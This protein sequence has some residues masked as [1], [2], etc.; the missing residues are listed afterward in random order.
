M[1]LTV[2]LDFGDA[3]APYPTLLA[4]NGARHEATGLTLG[5]NRDDELNGVHSTTANAD[6]T[7]GSPDDEDGVTFGT[8]QVGQ[9]GATVTVNVQGITTTGKLDAWIDFNGDGS[10]GGPGEQIA[11]HVAMVDGNNTLT[12]DVPSFAIDG[13]TFA[14][15][16]LSTAGNLGPEDAAADGE[17]EDY[18]VTI[19]P[20]TAASGVFGGQ[21]FVNTP[22]PDEPGS[23]VEGNADNAHSV[24]AADMDGDGDL[25]LLSASEGDDKIAWYENDGNQNF[26]Q[27]TIS[28]TAIG[29]SSVFAADVD[30]DG[31]L[32]VL[33]ASS[34]DAT[35][36]WYE[37][38]GSQNFTQHTISTTA[39]GPFS[40]FAADIDG[41]GDLDVL[42]AFYNDDTIAWYENDGNQNFTPHTI[43]TAADGAYSVFA[44]DVDGDGDMDVLSASLADDKIAWYENDGNQSFTPHTISSAADYTRSVFAADVDGDGDM[45]VLSASQNDDKIAWYENNG[46]QVFTPHTISTAADGAYSVFAADVDGDGDMDVLSASNY[47]DKIAWYENDGSQNFTP[48]TISTAANGANS[49]IAADVDGDGDLD[50]IST[51]VN[52]DKV[53]WY[54]NGVESD[55][56]GP[57]FTSGPTAAVPEQTTV[58]TTVD[59]SDES[60]PVMYSITGGADAARFRID[61]ETG[62]L[63]FFVAPDFELPADVGSDNVYHVEITATDALGNTTVQSLVVTVTNIVELPSTTRVKLAEGTLTIEDILDTTSDNLTL[64]V[65]N[66]ILR[67]SD[68]A[69]KISVVGG[70][71]FINSFLVEVNMEAVTLLIINTGAR[72]DV[73][74]IDFSGGNPIPAGGLTYNGGVGPTDSLVLKHVNAYFDGLKYRPTTKNDGSFE[75]RTGTG[76]E[77]VFFNVAF[78]HLGRVALENSPAEVF[79]DLPNS[80][81]AASITDVTGVGNQRFNIS[82]MMPLDFTAGDI[83]TLGMN[84]NGG[85]DTLSVY[86]LD[87]AFTGRVIIDGGDGNDVLNAAGAKTSTPRTGQA[88][89]ITPIHTRLFGGLGDDKLTGG[90]GNDTLVGGDGIDVLTGGDGNDALSGDLGNDKLDGGK[91]ND[92]LLGDA[93]KDTLLG[94]DGAD[95]CLGGNDDDSVDGGTAP[96]SL[97]DT[98]AGNA[99]NDKIKNPLAEIDELFTFDFAT[100]LT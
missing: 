97:R 77:A 43:S 69:A 4:D 36:A 67:V 2:S 83:T 30:G 1:L 61:S 74:T 91:G 8:I 66:G 32:D 38:D 26:T 31:D 50:V 75:L 37:N 87:N 44:A 12:F 100:L 56:T 19:N 41:D 11:D 18:A 98:V 82:N 46:S 53:A 27:H 22:D 3:P 35:V 13:T 64:S 17:V 6:D 48:H 95:L 68:T 58:V 73:L 33:A 60:G 23:G 86:S 71:S 81:N 28:T 80:S 40:V 96:A 15:F 85:N 10:W 20:P 89:L 7:T 55:R 70:V 94:G 49:V 45:D 24:F 21:N 42:S 79:L 72:S 47:D 25:D 88:A 92:T 34:N 59:A 29:A 16:R 84:G 63:T 9:L 39:N 54:E 52:D 57:V 14:R 76:K 65:K 62:A 90:I 99:G 51:S 93:G 78:S 5:T